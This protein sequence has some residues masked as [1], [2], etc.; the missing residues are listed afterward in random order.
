[1]RKKKRDLAQQEKNNFYPARKRTYNVPDKILIAVF[2]VR[3]K[4]AIRNPQSAI[5]YVPRTLAKS[6]SDFLCGTRT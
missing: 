1:M 4:S 6:E 3:F 5:R 2:G